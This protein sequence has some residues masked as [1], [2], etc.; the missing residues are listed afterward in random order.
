MMLRYF[1]HVT[2]NA[3]SLIFFLYYGLGSALAQNEPWHDW[4]SSRDVDHPL[5]GRIVALDSNRDLTPQQLIAELAKARYVLLGETHDNADHHRL[6]AWVIAE[7]AAKGRRPAVVMEMIREN[8]APALSAY[9]SGGAPDAAGL[10]KVLNW[11][12]GGWPDWAIY[13]P[14]AAVVL[15]TGLS[16]HAGD[17]AQ[18]VMRKVGR[19][20]Y[21]V[22][23][24]GKI[25][26]LGLDQSQDSALEEALR[27]ELYES[28]CQLMPKKALAPA[29]RVQHFRDAKLADAMISANQSD[30]AV[31]IAGG[32]H[33]RT[34]RAV[35]WYL[36]KRAPEA[37]ISSLI[38]LEAYPDAA[39]LNDLLPLDP[40]GR[41]AADYVWVT[42]RAERSD[43][44]EQLK[45]QF[46]SKMV[47]KDKP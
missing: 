11:D 6:Q 43:P 23:P 47:P 17:A 7:L 10:G 36:T 18:P 20:G 9:M 21:G 44:C 42:P 29:A 16:L 38:I 22:L 4:Q 1:G 45:E 14:I 32:G 8:Q 40:S 12:S 3:I 35:P 30:G 19:E 33:V 34:D 27:A 24:K 2:K 37:I 13:Q 25:A 46:K 31:L 28:H 41:P 39:M 15:R 26:R 5:V